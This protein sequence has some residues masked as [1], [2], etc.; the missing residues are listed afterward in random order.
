MPKEWEPGRC[1]EK[2]GFLFSH[3][4]FRYQDRICDRC[5]KPI[6]EDHTHQAEAETFCTSCLKK[7][8][9]KKA[10]TKQARRGNYDDRHDDSPYFYGGYHYGYSYFHTQDHHSSSMAHDP[11][12][13]TEADAESLELEAAGDFENDMSE[14]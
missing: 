13:F 2:S 3:G 12:D 11:A 4:C 5:Q 1:N 6:C 10:R 8:R 9:T 14:S 7:A